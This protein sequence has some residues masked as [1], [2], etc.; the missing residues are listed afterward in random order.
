MRN[1]YICLNLRDIA[2]HTAV[3]GSET[4]CVLQVDQVCFKK[5]GTEELFKYC[6]I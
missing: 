3:G 6:K 2:V 4:M 5:N 1:M